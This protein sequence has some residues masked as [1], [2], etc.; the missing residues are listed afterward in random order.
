MAHAKYAKLA[1]K[2]ISY[3]KYA[4]QPKKA[5]DESSAEILTPPLPAHSKILRSKR[6][7]PVIVHLVDQ[8]TGA[9][10]KEETLRDRIIQKNI[11]SSKDL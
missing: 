2:C 11:I 3:P 6:C 9:S 5:S 1:K 8:D 10:Q 7:L 4:K